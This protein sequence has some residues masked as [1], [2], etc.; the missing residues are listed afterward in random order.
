MTKKMMNLKLNMEKHFECVLAK[1]VKTNKKNH[2][3]VT[4]VKISIRVTKDKIN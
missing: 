4:N 3:N 2:I 1:D